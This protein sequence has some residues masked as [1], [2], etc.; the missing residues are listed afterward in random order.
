M[1]PGRPSPPP[2]TTARWGCLQLGANRLP[3]GRTEGPRLGFGSS[4]PGDPAT[5]TRVGFRETSC[6][7]GTNP[8]RSIK[9][10]HSHA[11]DSGAGGRGPRRRSVERRLRQTGRLGLAVGCGRPRGGRVGGGG[12]GGGGFNPTDPNRRLQSRAMLTDPQAGG[13]VHLKVEALRWRVEFA[14]R[15]AAERW[16]PGGNGGVFPGFKPGLEV[17]EVGR[18]HPNVPFRVQTVL[19]VSENQVSE[20]VPGVSRGSQQS[21]A[22]LNASQWRDGSFGS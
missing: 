19:K 15:A 4:G 18:R 21:V 5:G 2:P 17:P 7:S 1:R 22:T 3:D 6:L 11:K 12:G 13:T 16:L 8:P 10:P 20:I 9:Q 14:Y